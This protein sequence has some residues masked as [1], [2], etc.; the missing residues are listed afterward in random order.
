MWRWQL[1]QG[2]EVILCRD[3]ERF[4]LANW[5]Y[6]QHSIDPKRVFWESLIRKVQ[7]RLFTTPCFPKSKCV[8]KNTIPIQNE[9]NCTM[10]CICSPN[11][12]LVLV[13][14]KHSLITNTSL[15][16]GSVLTQSLSVNNERMIHGYIWFGKGHKPVCLTK[17]KL[18]WHW[19]ISKCKIVE[20]VVLKFWDLIEEEHLIV[21]IF[22][23]LNYKVG[24][25][26]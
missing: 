1:L 18:E 25:K 2:N 19:L 22:V 16:S 3:Y 9:W 8:A 21:S 15:G 4:L 10:Y 13:E 11:T 26:T 12:S 6:N 24:A 5:S 23:C 14:F 7:N 20:N 17:W